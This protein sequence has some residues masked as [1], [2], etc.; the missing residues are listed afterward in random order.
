MAT[1]SI[2]CRFHHSRDGCRRGVYCKFSHEET[3]DSVDVLAFCSADTTYK[4]E[5]EYVDIANNRERV[6]D[7]SI[8]RIC[9]LSAASAVNTLKNKMLSAKIENMMR[10][11]KESKNKID[12][13]K[14]KLEESKNE[15]EQESIKRRRLEDNNEKSKL[16]IICKE[17]PA[18]MGIICKCRHITC[19]SCYEKIRSC[20]ICRRTFASSYF[21]TVPPSPLSSLPESPS[22]VRNVQ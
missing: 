10:Q 8:D 2:P 20:P 18:D 16:C 5:A 3:Q 11:L 9:A 4:H 7:S 14:R 19:S 21:A 17:I 1:Q 12:H 22:P 13:I 15:T 6:N